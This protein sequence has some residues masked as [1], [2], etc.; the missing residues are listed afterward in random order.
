MARQMHSLT[1]THEESGKS[2]VITGS[3]WF[4]VE[5]KA[6]AQSRSWSA[7]WAKSEEARRARERVRQQ[8]DDSRRL[9]KF[10]AQ[11]AKEAKVLHRQSQESFA[12]LRTAEAQAALLQVQTLLAHTLK[13]DD[14]IDWDALKRRTPFQEPAPTA[15]VVPPLQLSK[16]SVEPKRSDA[17]FNRAPPE[18]EGLKPKPRKPFYKDPEFRPTLNLAQ[19]L[20]TSEDEQDRL[21]KAACETAT[22]EW[23]RVCRDIERFNLRLLSESLARHTALMQGLYEQAFETWDTR[24]QAVEMENAR[25]TAVHAR[26]SAAADAAWQVEFHQHEL[27]RASYEREREQHNAKV[28]EYR[29]AFDAGEPDAVYDYFDLVLSASAYPEAFPREWEMAYLADS[30]MLV[31]DFVLPQPVDMPTLKEVRYQP[32]KD[33]FKEMLSTDKEVRALYDLALYQI[34]LRT[35]HEVFEADYPETLDAAVFN[36][37]V[38]SVDKATGRQVSACVLS[39]QVGKAEFMALDLA[40]VDPKACFKALKGVGSSQLHS[41]ARVAPIVK[42]D[43]YDKR[44]VE[45]YAVADSLDEASNLATMDWEDFEHLVREVFEREFS[46][47]GGE[48]KVTRASRDGGVDAVAFDPD[49]IRG[50]KI[51]I[52]AKR[53]ANTVGVSA[54]RDLY[55]TVMNEGAIKGILVSTANY[56]SDAYE[57]ANG[58]PLTLLNGGNLLHLLARHGHKA[59]INLQAARTRSVAAPPPSMQA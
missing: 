53:Y 7:M 27:R 35:L 12:E 14:R 5:A 39:V 52:Q 6:Q 25:R 34:A 51:V 30:K 58:K 21:A 9:S 8:R 15:S 38:R 33:D 28:D 56:G 46:A 42:L 50:G 31:I 45:S 47:T 16:L 22:A 13:V 37:V 24:H 26:E 59:T 29:R 40:Q 11:Q 32:T 36:G 41:L 1:V 49:P 55:G 20:L 23:M 43:T 54:V 19:R 17:E 4:I 57:F 3:D 2:R 44:F 10:E 18:P 48:V